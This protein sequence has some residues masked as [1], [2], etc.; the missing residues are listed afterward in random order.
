[1]PRGTGKLE[2]FLDGGL[3]DGND[4][5]KAL[6]LGA[7]AVGVGRPFLY[8]LGA[9]GSKGVERCVDSKFDCH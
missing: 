8:V 7:T 6:W 1:M 4:V 2:V 9:Y 5:L 3:R